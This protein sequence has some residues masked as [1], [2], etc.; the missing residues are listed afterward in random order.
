MRISSLIT[1]FVFLFVSFS[2]C[3]F[4]AP[5]NGFN[6]R[7]SEGMPIVSCDTILK[8]EEWDGKARLKP[9]TC[10]FVDSPVVVT[11]NNILPES[12]MIVI[13]NNGKLTVKENVKFNVKGAVIVHSKANLVIDGRV[14]LKSASASVINGRLLIGGKGRVSVYGDLQISEEG[15]MGVKGRVAVHKNGAVLNYGAIKKMSSSAVFPDDTKDLHGEIPLYVAEE[16]S[17]YLDNNITICSVIDDDGLTLKDKAT[18]QKLIRSF[19][20]VVY[21]YDGEFKDVSVFILN[22]LFYMRIALDNDVRNDIYAGMNA[23]NCIAYYEWDEDGFETAKGRFYSSVLGKVDTSLF[24]EVD[25][26]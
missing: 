23:W 14:I 25:P 26:R 11:A 19:E 13:E 10:Y 3:A 20:S 22:H 2:V 7:D 4:A 12:S 16:Y 18:K 5:A 15:I 9:E 24:A 21:K 8:Q 6:E 1:A 17:D